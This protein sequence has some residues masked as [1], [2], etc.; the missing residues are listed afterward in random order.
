MITTTF[1]IVNGLV[2]VI[3]LWMFIFPRKPA[4][5][6]LLNSRFL[7]WAAGVIYASLLIGYSAKLDWL[8]MAN[9][10]YAGIAKL[11]ATPEVAAIAWLHLLIFDLLAGRHILI[12][13]QSKNRVVR[14]FLLVTLMAGPLGFALY[15]MYDSLLD[16]RNPGKYNIL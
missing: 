9:P 4:T 2:L 5:F 6:A 15:F 13:S 11:F 1:Q 12:H 3:W 16:Y 14:P 7:W 10:T 8:A